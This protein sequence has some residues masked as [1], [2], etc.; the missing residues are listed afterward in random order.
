MWPD[1]SPPSDSP[2]FSISSITYLSP[3]DGADQ[4]DAERLQRQLEADVAHHRR[5]DGV[6]LQPPFAL[7]LPAA[8]QQ[9]GVA[10]DDLPAMI[11]EDRAVAVA[12]ERDA[13]PASAARRP[14]APA[15]RDA[16]IRSSG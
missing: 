4:L 8:H 11:D 5:D 13:H 3:T 15:A 16:S 9:H 7:Q 14:S 6:A 12:V 10:V 1:C 2:R